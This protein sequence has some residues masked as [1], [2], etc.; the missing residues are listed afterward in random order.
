[1]TTTLD[2][3]TPRR[4]L[5]IGAHPDDIEFGCGASLSKWAD[6]G[7]VVHLAVCSDGSKGTWDGAADGRALIETRRVEQ[8][9]AAKVLGAVDVEFL[10]GVDGELGHGLG[11]RSI[12][13][14]VI[15]RTQ[16]D[17]VLGHDPWPIGRIHPDHRHAGL[18]AIEAI[19]AARDPHFFPE[20]GLEPHRPQLLLLFE[21]ERA[22]HVERVDNFLERK[23]EALLCHRSQWRS[24]MG[25]DD[26]PEEQRDAFI[27]RVYDTAQA[28]GL[29]AGLRAGESFRRVDGL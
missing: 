17:I 22:D 16:P 8:R 7:A 12:V 26:R 29:R 3:P 23:I 28:Q 5:A 18:L 25:I 14:A 11:A 27:R 20:Q 10:D 4:V 13:C 6:R 19:V 2:L 24:T 21:S 15:R 1:V 9:E